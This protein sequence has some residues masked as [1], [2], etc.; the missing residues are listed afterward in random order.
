MIE[1]KNV[2]Y[3]YFSKFYT[4][5]NFSY[6]F[7]DGNYCLIGD[8]VS[9]GLTL[10]RLLAKLDTY[11]KGEILINGTNLKKVNYKKD[12]N[13][14]YI[15]ATPKFLDSKTVLENIAYPLKVRGIKKSQRNAIG[16]E[17]LS[18]FGWND[19]ANLKTKTLTADE[20][21]TLA[22]M[23]AS[24]R[25]LD[26]LLCENIFDKVSV[27]ILNAINAKTKILV[28][29]NDLNLNNCE[30]LVFNLGQLK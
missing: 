20:K 26:L 29:N 11:Y 4:L 27:D 12:F 15:S 30:K 21:I 3:T 28:T 16:L 19:K 22:I 23:R 13:V 7:N 1:F 17:A 8:N 5:F 14:A 6:Q 24:T 18:R 2:S 10:I 9:G 25:Q